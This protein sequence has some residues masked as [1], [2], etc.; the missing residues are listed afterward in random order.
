M[1]NQEMVEQSM[2]AQQIYLDIVRRRHLMWA[3]STDDPEIK[4]RHN[5]IADLIQQTSFQ[6]YDLFNA[7]HDLV[8]EQ[9]YELHI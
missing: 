2:L 7:Y 8:G 9:V 1:N 3:N 6:Y 4:R 5:E